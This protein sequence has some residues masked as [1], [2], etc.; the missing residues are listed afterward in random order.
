MTVDGHPYDWH[1]NPLDDSIPVPAVGEAGRY[2]RFSPFLPRQ[3]APTGIWVAN[4]ASTLPA[5]VLTMI[6]GPYGSLSEV[7]A[8]ALAADV[9]SQ[10]G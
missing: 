5:G 4:P 6:Q 2:L 10:V 3:V 9:I 1:A 8:L 7:S